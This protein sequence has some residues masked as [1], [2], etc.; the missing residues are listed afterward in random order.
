MGPL[1]Y[2]FLKKIS[3]LP[4]ANTT[5][6]SEIYSPIIPD[7][8]DI[9]KGYS[10]Y[11]VYG[12]G[13]KKPE[14]RKKVLIIGA[15]TSGLC[16]GYELNKSG[17]E[18]EI[19]EASSRVGGRVK[20]FRDPIFA[21][22]LHGEGGAMR[23]PS[24]HFLTMGYINKFGLPLFPFEMEN[25]FIYLRGL[26]KTLTYAQFN[27]MLKS[28]DPT[29][30][31][32]FPGLREE[33]K[34]KTCDDLWDEA[35]APVYELFAK[36]YQDNP[37]NLATAYKEVTQAFDKY[38]LR[39]F[40][41][42][43]ARWS[44]DAINLYDLGNAHVVFENGFIESWKDSFL[45]SNQG[46]ESAK[47]QQL[48]GGM[49]TLPL[50]F[51]RDRTIDTNTLIDKI[52]FGARVTHIEETSDGVTSDSRSSIKLTYDT[53]AGQRS[54]VGDWL[55][56]AIPYTALRVITRSKPF[57]PLKELAIRTVRYVEVT[58]VLLQYRERWW[59]KE[60]EKEGQGTDGGVV[61]DLPIRYT[62]FPREADSD[63]ARASDR[64]VVMAAYTFE[65]DAT[66]LGS[67]SPAN[68]ALQAARDLDTIFGDA[69]SLPLLEASAAQ[70]FP[71]D[72]LAGGSAFTY[73]APMQKSM[74]LEDMCRAEWDKRVFFAGEQASYTHGWIQGA[75]EAGLRCA[76][77]LYGE[78][79]SGILPS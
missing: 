57:S 21:P 33:E 24:N 69:N 53:Q 6:D 7:E 73:F 71:S 31:A 37:K 74:F 68:R 10:S 8:S 28:R 67:M 38:T 12:L 40:L 45:S 41:S 20:T 47:M 39:T 34:G 22:G 9:L 46:G 19:L 48:Q 14:R 32:L 75:F 79:T 13:D 27:Q 3:S 52:R 42:D 58:K 78:A 60:F 44:P 64:G 56:I 29:L 1:A 5:E 66:I 11:I 77:E 35:V 76:A 26:G 50:C 43:F 59:K 2:H 51:I 23:I 17:F 4:P 62:M 63:M 15:G 72:E 70:V 61:T 54:V 55:I 16:A 30:L 18:V 49:D 36:Y 25:K 65:Q